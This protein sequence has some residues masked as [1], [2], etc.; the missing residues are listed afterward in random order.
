MNFEL[1]WGDEKK[2][3]DYSKD[4]SGI[5]WAVRVQIRQTGPTLKSR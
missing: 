4:G 3:L 1:R 5:R 2:R